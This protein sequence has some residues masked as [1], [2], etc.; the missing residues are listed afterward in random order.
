[1]V[2][3]HVVPELARWIP[4]DQRLRRSTRS[5]LVTLNPLPFSAFMMNPRMVI[6][7]SKAIRASSRCKD[8]RIFKVN[9]LDVS[10][11]GE[12]DTWCAEE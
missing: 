6:L 3:I 12:A 5:A 8:L 4:F 9:W 2:C 7:A 1:M 10:W 11:L